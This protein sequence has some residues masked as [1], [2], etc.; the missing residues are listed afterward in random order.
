[1]IRY[2]LKCSDAHRFDGWFS[3]S[4]DFDRQ[5]AADQIG[6]VVC[7]STAIDKDLM[8]PRVGAGKDKDPIEGGKGALHAPASPAEQ[9]LRE[10][11][12]K[13]EATSENVGRGFATEARRIHE[14][15]APAR[16]IMGEARPTEVRELIEDGIKIAPLP[17]SA[18]K[19]N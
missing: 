15:D 1:M 13:I 8:A 14:G 4:E 12:R 19:S 3:S 10:L 9:A 11:R 18:R 7:G 6:C 2:A 5:R 17:W 16:P